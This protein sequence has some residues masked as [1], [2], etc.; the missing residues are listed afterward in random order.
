[1][2]VSAKKLMRNKSKQNE[3]TFEEELNSTL[4]RSQAK[5]QLVQ[6]RLH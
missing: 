1:M 6:T 2:S 4:R 5:C 3:Q